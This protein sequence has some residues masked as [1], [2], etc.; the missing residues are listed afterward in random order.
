MLH[1]DNNSIAHTM[2]VLQGRDLEYYGIDAH[3]PIPDAIRE[4]GV[5]VPQTRNPRSPEQTNTAMQIVSNAHVIDEYGIPL[6]MTVREYVIGCLSV[7]VGC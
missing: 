2:E 5:Y 4:S 6:Y 7:H 1:Q 3:A